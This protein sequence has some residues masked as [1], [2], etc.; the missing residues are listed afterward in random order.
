MVSYTAR[1]VLPVSR[2]PIR[3]GVVTIERGLVTRVGAGSRDSGAIDLGSVAV[4]PG[5]VNAHT[6]LELSWMRGQVPPSDSMPLWAAGLMS[7]RRTVS[8]EPAEPIG[9][10]IAEARACGTALV[11]DV[12]NT[13]ATYEW[14][15]NSDLSAVLFRELVGFSAPD[16][17]LLVRTAADQIAALPPAA[18]VRASI[19][20]HAPYSVAPALFD[21]IRRYAANRPVSVHLGESPDEIEFLRAGTGRWR[22]LLESLGVWNDQWTPPGCGAVEYLE[23]FDLVNDRLLAVHGVQFTDDDLA[24]LRR[25][26]ATVVTCP[27]SNAWTGA[28][29]PPVGRFYASGV[30]VA[31]GTDSLASV[32]DLN[33][34]SELAAVRRLAPRV[35][36]RELLASATEHGAAALGFADEFGTIDPGKP[37]QLIAVRIPE[38][39]A[40]VEEYLVGGIDAGDVEWL[41]AERELEP[42]NRTLTPEA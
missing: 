19:V 36:A 23:R 37:A 41:D 22:A 14:I 10:A 7:L 16:P 15:A 9:A 27:R 28:G 32:G 21:A 4:L 3:G 40:D 26:G 24:R 42:R 12:T 1:W 38:H 6:H 20:P 11:G 30:R 34:F 31:I 29:E 25:A 13:L 8:L 18:S 2:P 35:P 5:L 39:V 17:D 33:L